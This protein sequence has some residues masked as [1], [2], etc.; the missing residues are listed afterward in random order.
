MISR[1]IKAKKICKL[2]KKVI[3]IVKERL[4]HK[5]K[6]IRSMQ[7]STSEEGVYFEDGNSWFCNKCWKLVNPEKK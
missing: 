6:K 5:S 3:N 4:G 1:G 2:C 7:I